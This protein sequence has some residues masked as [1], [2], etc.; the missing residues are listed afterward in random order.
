MDASIS[1]PNSADLH[2]A[3]GYTA[4]CLRAWPAAST[5]CRPSP[6][7]T[8]RLPRKKNS[9]GVWRDCTTVVCRSPICCLQF[10]TLPFATYLSG[11]LYRLDHHTTPH[12]PRLLPSIRLAQRLHETAR[13]TATAFP[14]AAHTFPYNICSITWWIVRRQCYAG[15]SGLLLPSVLPT[16]FCYPATTIW[17]GESSIS[18]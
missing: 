7:P 9:R 3:R 6:L 16:L 8:P 5:A 14:A 13:Y 15:E 2:R 10:G 17:D 12:T 11:S 18:G 4:A 1:F